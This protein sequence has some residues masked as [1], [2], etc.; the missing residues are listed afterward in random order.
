MR[1]LPIVQFLKDNVPMLEGRVEQAKALTALT[2]IE[3]KNDLPMAFVYPSNESSTGADTFSA[4]YKVSTAFTV[5]I[6]SRPVNEDEDSEPLE[7][8]RDQIMQALVG[9]KVEPSGSVVVFSSGVILDVNSKLIWW[10]D[11]FSFSVF[12]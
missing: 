2:D 5:V 7:E 4:T 10:A 3:I 1:I 8:V 9:H 6:A 11:T 12:R